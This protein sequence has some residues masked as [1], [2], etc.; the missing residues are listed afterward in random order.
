MALSIFGLALSSPECTNK[1]LFI[2]FVNFV[3]G[4]NLEDGL[5]QIIKGFEKVEAV[6][7]GESEGKTNNLENL[8]EVCAYFVAYLE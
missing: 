8:K 7:N 1:V 2:S 6:L 3:R 4:L 5:Q